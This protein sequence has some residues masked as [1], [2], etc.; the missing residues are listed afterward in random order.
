MRREQFHERGYLI[1]DLAEHSSFVETTYLLWHLE[2]PS[3]QQLEDLRTSLLAERALPGVVYD[4]LKLVSSSQ[5]PMATSVSG[6]AGRTPS[7]LPA[8]DP[9]L[10]HRFAHRREVGPVEPGA[11]APTPGPGGIG[12]RSRRS[13]RTTREMSYLKTGQWAGFLAA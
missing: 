12:R 8:T 1:K 11:V 7:R 3:R 4:T 6:V 9:L 2:L 10:R 5:E 13:I